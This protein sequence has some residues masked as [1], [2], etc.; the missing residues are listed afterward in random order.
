MTNV[1][2]NETSANET[3]TNDRDQVEGVS[4]PDDVIAALDTATQAAVHAARSAYNKRNAAL[5]DDATASLK[6]LGTVNV[7]ALDFKGDATPGMARAFEVAE[8]SDGAFSAAFRAEYA[9]F[10]SDGAAR[11][12]MT[13]LRKLARTIMSWTEETFAVEYGDDGLAHLATKVPDQKDVHRR[14][15]LLSGAK[16]KASKPASGK[17]T[18]GAAGAP[19]GGAGLETAP[20]SAPAT[21]QAAAPVHDRSQVDALMAAWTTVHKV[22][23]SASWEGRCITLATGGDAARL[24]SALNMLGRQ[25]NVV[26]GV[27]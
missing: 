20:T 1:T 3:G 4:I 24:Q 6:Y 18:G 5:G 22:L 9:K 14:L 27:E 12:A 13:K 16:G 11:A 25:V 17:V 8:Q 10:S 19:T 21:V 23:A 2:T 26:C 7:A 15:I